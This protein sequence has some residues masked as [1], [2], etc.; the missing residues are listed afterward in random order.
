MVLVCVAP[1]KLSSRPPVPDDEEEKENGIAERG[2]LDEVEVGFDAKGKGKAPISISLKK[3]C[4]VCK[5]PRHEDLILPF[6]N[7]TSL[8]S[9]RSRLRSMLWVI[10]DIF[11]G[12]KDGSNNEY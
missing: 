7:S 12:Y 4:K 5:K 8:D 1:Q 10:N 9:G 2:D 3:V 6:P 11:E